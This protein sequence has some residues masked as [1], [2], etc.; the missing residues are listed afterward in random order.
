MA[1]AFRSAGTPVENAGATTVTVSYTLTAG[2]LLLC[3]FSIHDELTA[4]SGATWNGSEAMTL[5]GYIGNSG[6]RGCGLYLLSGGTSGT[7]DVVI[8]HATSETMAAVAFGYSGHDTGTPYDGAVTD[9]E[10]TGDTSLSVTV[11][12]P[13]GDLALV[14]A[15]VADPSVT[16][17]L[18]NGTERA[19]PDT[20]N[21]GFFILDRAGVGSTLINGTFSA[22]PFGFATVGVNLNDRPVFGPYHMNQYR[23]MMTGAL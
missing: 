20:T 14:V 3:A 1:V 7:H 19:A 21:F 4:P 17:S 8:T 5:V 10:L 6:T 12:S 13:A 9:A 18:T 22:D 15:A 16:L 2:D 23:K 11:T